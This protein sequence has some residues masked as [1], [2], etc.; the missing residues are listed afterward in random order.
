MAK[1]RKTIRLYH[2]LTTKHAEDFF[3]TGELKLCDL[4]KSNDPNDFLPCIENAPR[5]PGSDM[6][7][8][9]YSYQY[10]REFAQRFPR[11]ALCCSAKTTSSATWGH[12]ADCH[13][14]VCLAFDFPISDFRLQDNVVIGNMEDGALFERVLYTNRRLKIP[15]QKSSEEGFIQKLISAMGYKG[16]DWSY[17]QECRLLYPVGP[18]LTTHITARDGLFFVNGLFKYLVGIILGVN[19]PLSNAYFYT[20]L[21]NVNINSYAKKSAEHIISGGNI[22]RAILDFETVLIKTPKFRNTDLKQ[23]DY[24]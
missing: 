22:D 18:G 4:S 20:L 16:A 17:E 21:Q 2:Y 7:A 9:S 19:C 6:I 5:Y 11:L 13:R 15:Q 10:V 12:Y 23:L 24:V 8:L 14:G 1:G 3:K